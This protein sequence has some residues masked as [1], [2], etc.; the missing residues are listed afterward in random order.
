MIRGGEDLYSQVIPTIAMSCIIP[1]KKGLYFKIFT[2]D[3]SQFLS[4]HL[5]QWLFMSLVK[6]VI[7]GKPG[8][9]P[10]RCVIQQIQEL[11]ACGVLLSLL[12][13]RFTRTS[14]W[15]KYSSKNPEV[16]FVSQACE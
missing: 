11:T 2:S 4:P 12:I 15:M 5:K 8:D 6:H 10:Q 1:P 14:I 3:M 9:I 7:L 16:N 13:R